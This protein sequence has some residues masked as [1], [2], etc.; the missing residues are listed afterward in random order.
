[1]TKD[2][3][4]EF[5]KGLNEDNHTVKKVKF[6]ELK[7][8]FTSSGIK[9]SLKHLNDVKVIITAELG[10][11]ILKGQEIF[12]LRRGKLIILNKVVGE[13]VDLYINNQRFAKGEV[14]VIGDIFAIRISSVYPAPDKV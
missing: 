12:D 7:K 11:T 4:E 9:V 14:L 2:E 13:Q 8:A 1:M 6:P 10:S 3:I 5:L